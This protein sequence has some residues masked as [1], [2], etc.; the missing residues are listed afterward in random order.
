MGLGDGRPLLAFFD[1][2]AAFPSLYHTYL[3]EALR[4]AKLPTGLLSFAS[5]IYS[6]VNAR[7]CSGDGSWQ[8]LCFVGRGVLQGCPL[9]GALFVLIA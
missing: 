6:L 7:M 1:F 8:H 4:A 3:F 5:S 9:S 2:A